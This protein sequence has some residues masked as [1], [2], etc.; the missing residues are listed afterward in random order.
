MHIKFPAPVGLYAFHSLR[1]LSTS[2]FIEAQ[3]LPASAGV[4]VGQRSST[5]V[6]SFL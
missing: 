5:P 6:F 2:V 3:N 1:D 4:S